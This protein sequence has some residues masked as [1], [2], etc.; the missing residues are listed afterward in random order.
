MNKM[1]KP[2]SIYA[3][4]VLLIPALGALACLLMVAHRN[5]GS[6]ERDWR[7]L[8]TLPRQQ[9]G[10]GVVSN[11]PLLVPLPTIPP[12]GTTRLLVQELGKS[13]PSMSYVFHR[14]G[15]APPQGTWELSKVR[16]RAQATM[17]VERIPTLASPRMIQNSLPA[18]ETRVDRPVLFV[19][20]RRTKIGFFA[21]DS[22]SEIRFR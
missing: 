8:R 1:N 22:S 13:S 17:V 3:R 14:R 20:G 16:P 15:Q 12:G 18:G 2:R 21:I 5:V 19:T 7:R 9:W 4:L 11:M 6:Q 10:F